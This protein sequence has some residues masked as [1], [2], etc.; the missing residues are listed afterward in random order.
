M[1]FQVII[2]FF[3]YLIILLTNIPASAQTY[4]TPDSLSTNHQNAHSNWYQHKTFQVTAVPLLLTASGL[5]LWDYREGVRSL[6]N[7]FFKDF[8]TKFDDYLFYAPVIT[9]YGL[10]AVGVKGQN[11]LGRATLGLGLSY[12]MASP[13][14]DLLK[15]KTNVQRPGGG[16]NSFP[17]WH[18]TRAFIAATFL[19]KEYGHRSPWYSVA[20]YTVA[21]TTGA[22]RSL[23]NAHWISDVLVGAGIG[24]FTT[25]LS[26]QLLDWVLKDKW[27]NK[28]PQNAYQYQKGK[29]HFISIHLGYTLPLDD[30]DITYNELVNGEGAS[31]KNGMMLGLEGAYFITDRWGIGGSFSVRA[32]NFDTEPFPN[33]GITDE[34]LQVTAEAYGV[35]SVMV[36]PYYTLPVSD[37]LAVVFKSNF[38]WSS[39]AVGKI[40]LERLSPTSTVQQSS[41]LL[42]YIPEDAFSF[43]TGAILRQMVSQNIALHLALEYFHSNQKIRIISTS[44]LAQGDAIPLN[45]V[46]HKK[47]PL[48]VFTLSTGISLML[49]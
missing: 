37:K 4:L 44:S 5:A 1:W 26:Y 27:Q 41:P 8:N 25:E 38:G 7:R 20:G 11:K 34:M 29:P 16:D 19:H 45:I 49:W 24:I 22:L 33:E 43:S 48:D 13:I 40:N 47:N 32:F 9:V 21:T 2:S 18:T 31:M 15:N 12:A 14:V 30:L 39:H 17:S 46:Y 36:G 6:R 42:K 28:L 10:N 3:L 35:R 23:N